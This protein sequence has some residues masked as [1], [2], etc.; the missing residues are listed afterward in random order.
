M[1]FKTE[2]FVKLKEILKVLKVT[3]EFITNRY[4]D[5]VH[6]ELSIRNFEFEMFIPFR[7]SYSMEAHEGRIGH[8]LQSVFPADLAD[9]GERCFQQL[10][11]ISDNIYT[12]I[13]RERLGLQLRNINNSM[14]I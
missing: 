12:F 4:P 6:F 5:Q 13:E 2:D 8:Q 14:F 3:T 1:V 10:D 7:N 9:Q 11:I